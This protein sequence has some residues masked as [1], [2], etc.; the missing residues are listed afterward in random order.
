MVGA[1]DK[2]IKSKKKF[3]NKHNYNIFRP[4]DICV[5]I[6]NKHCTCELHH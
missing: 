6:S 4:F 2:E 5:I 3:G 1:F